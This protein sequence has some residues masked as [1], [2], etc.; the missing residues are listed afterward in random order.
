MRGIRRGV[1]QTSIWACQKEM[2]TTGASTMTH[3]SW[4]CGVAPP[5]NS[6]T[7]QAVPAGSTGSTTTHVHHMA[8]CGLAKESRPPVPPPRPRTCLLSARRGE[9][10]GHGRPARWC[11]STANSPQELHSEPLQWGCMGLHRYA[12]MGL[13]FGG[14]DGGAVRIG[15]ADHAHTLC[16][17]VLSGD[18]A[19]GLPQHR[20]GQSAATNGHRKE[21]SPS[22]ACLVHVVQPSFCTI[23]V[24]WRGGGD[25]RMARNG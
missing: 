12:A 1:G 6:P 4:D 18:A 11:L 24:C 2:G 19:G 8:T 16:I 9:R 3:E 10:G 14:T 21:G 20:E 17:L 5:A 23:V 15:L 22:F 13:T 7:G 25:E